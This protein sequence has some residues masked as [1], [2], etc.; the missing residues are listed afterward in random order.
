MIKSK[1]GLIKK[2]V[3]EIKESHREGKLRDYLLI[4]GAQKA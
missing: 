3:S 1:I 4:E 2:T